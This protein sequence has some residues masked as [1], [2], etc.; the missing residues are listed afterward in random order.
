MKQKELIEEFRA[1]RAEIRGMPDQIIEKEIEMHRHSPD[2]LIEAV[3]ASALNKLDK[4]RE[5][6]LWSHVLLAITAIILI[7][8]VTMLSL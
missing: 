2:C 3:Y 8:S 5:V 1:L 4:S 6:L 7:V